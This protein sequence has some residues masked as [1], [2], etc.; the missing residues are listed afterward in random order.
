M[1]NRAHADSRSGLFG[2]FST[3]G[4]ADRTLSDAA[5]TLLAVCTHVWKEMWCVRLYTAGLLVPCGA[6]DN[7]TTN[8]HR[9]SQNLLRCRAGHAASIAEP[10]PVLL[11]MRRLL[12]L[13]SPAA[14]AGDA[15]VDAA[16]A[17]GCPLAPPPAHA[18][19][20]VA[21]HGQAALMP[22]RKGLGAAVA[23]PA[24]EAYAVRWL[25]IRPN[26]AHLLMP[27]NEDGSE[28]QQQHRKGR[29]RGAPDRGR[30][31]LVRPH[32]RISNAI[33][34][35]DFAEKKAFNDQVP[36]T[37]LPGP[38]ILGKETLKKRSRSAF[39][40]WL[41]QRFAQLPR[42]LKNWRRQITPERNG[43]EKI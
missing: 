13:F 27:R 2:C 12:L 28:R 21:R 9:S 15:T 8:L 42:P 24:A 3:F 38:L 7:K 29:R 22:G 41:K 35:H 30:T 36:R 19:P 11:Q 18:R 43:G 17:T 25:G 1:L 39:A 31:C 32:S 26:A 34:R 33:L 14:A 20:P 4:I 23:T 10:L 40:G 16:A 37:D 6:S 5:A